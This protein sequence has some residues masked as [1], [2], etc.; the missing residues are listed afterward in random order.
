MIYAHVPAMKPA[1]SKPY[2]PVR[3][4]EYNIIDVVDRMKDILIA[5]NTDYGSSVSK[6]LEKYG[7]VAF[8]VRLEDKFNRLEHLYRTKDNLVKDESFEDTI[9]DIAGYCL[10][11]L[12][13]KEYENE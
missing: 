4:I 10:L 5:K 9:R 2:I 13:I 12:S 7:A 6:T 3:N 8:M 11:Y 1:E